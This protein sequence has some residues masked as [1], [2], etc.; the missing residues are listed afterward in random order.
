MKLLSQAIYFQF[1]RAS[2]DVPSVAPGYAFMFN[3][4]TDCATVEE[5][6][7][8]C[9]HIFSRELRVKFLSIIDV[10]GRLEP[11]LSDERALALNDTNIARAVEDCMTKKG[12]CLDALRGI[13]T[14]DAPTMTGKKGRSCEVVN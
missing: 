11:H 14:D 6:V 8:H 4:T 2:I 5:L 7:I 13:G 12:L 1:P 10:L 3:E 9:R